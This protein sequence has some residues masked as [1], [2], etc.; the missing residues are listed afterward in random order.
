MVITLLRD[1]DKHTLYGTETLL[2]RLEVNAKEMKSIAEILADR[3]NIEI[4]QLKRVAYVANNQVL[5]IYIYILEYGPTPRNQL[6]KVFPSSTLKRI[7]PQLE[8]AEVI[9]YR[10]HRYMVKRMEST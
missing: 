3:A 8:A 1:F 9:V 4:S 10:N 2:E 6:N 7:L 5:N